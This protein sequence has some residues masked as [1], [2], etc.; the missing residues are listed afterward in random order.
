[1]TMVGSGT[2]ILAW[3]V[4]Q[5]AANALMV[6]LAAKA[7]GP[8]GQGHY[9]LTMTITLVLASVLNGG[10]GLAAVPILRRGDVDPRRALAAQAFWAVTIGGVLVAAALV[11]P[12]STAWPELTARLGWDQAILVAA[13]VTV[14]AMLTSDVHTYDLL[15][16]GRLVTGTLVGALRASAHLAVL[17]WLSVAGKL[18]LQTAVISYAAVYAAAAVVLA[19]AAWRVLP[20]LPFARPSLAV[21]SVARLAGRFV[22]LGWV[23]QLSA[24]SY[25]LLLRL[26]QGFLEFGHGAAAVGIYSVAVWATEMLWLL[27]EAINPL[28]VHA[29]ADDRV[30]A[31]R[32]AVAARAVRV[33]LALTTVGALVLGAIAR[34]L[35][36]VLLGGAYLT[37]VPALLALLPG[38]ILLAPGAVLAGD[39]IG[40]GRPAW[41]TQA[42]VVTVA[43]NVVLCAVLIP[44]AAAVGAAWAS[45]L[46]Y[47]VGS[48]VMLTRFRRATGIAWR[49]LLLPRRA[50][51]VR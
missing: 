30:P 1:M 16:A 22:R 32:D 27:P 46:A 26:D 33:A 21:P 7:L 6:L 48:L 28:L 24:V 8:V 13:V 10:V 37:A 3:R 17:A 50:D 11:I 35:F 36:G 25:L 14:L 12:R 43:V 38:T 49:D 20:G 18:D 45:T 23:G 5:K 47:G 39:F 4:V 29:S 9:A 41:N 34:P 2:R 19:V 42:S 44:P 51:F 40:R 31:A 15:V